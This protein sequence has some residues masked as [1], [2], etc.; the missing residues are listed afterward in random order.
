MHQ[1]A[2]LI[3]NH[4]NSNGRRES[5]LARAEEMTAM[6]DTTGA[7]MRP[8]FLVSSWTMPTSPPRSR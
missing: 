7:P 5:D 2:L 4:K 6:R 3:R 8:F 1:I